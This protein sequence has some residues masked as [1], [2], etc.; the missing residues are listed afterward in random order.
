MFK[1]SKV[2]GRFPNNIKQ[3][4]YFDYSLPDTKL[5]GGSSYRDGRVEVFHKRSLGNR[6]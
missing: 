2:H 4:L 1:T 6:V 5:V 3:L